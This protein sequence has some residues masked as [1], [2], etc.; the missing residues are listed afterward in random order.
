MPAGITVDV[1]GMDINHTVR[2]RDLPLEPVRVRVSDHI[3]L[4]TIYKH[5][6]PLSATLWRPFLV[7][8]KNFRGL[9]SHDLNVSLSFYFFPARLVLCI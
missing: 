3:D 1:S 6:I 2:L 9:K 5:K 4:Y 8:A 7:L